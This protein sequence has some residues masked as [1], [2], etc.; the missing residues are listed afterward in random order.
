LTYLQLA[1][2]HL[3]TVLP[4]FVLGTWLLLSSRKGSPGH[5]LIG[6]VYMVLML[7]TAG[8]TLFMPAAVGPRVLNHFGFIHL[9][10][11][12]T[13]NAIPR[14]YLAARQH[15][16]AA[17][18]RHMIALYVGALLIAGAFAFAPG[19]LLHHWLFG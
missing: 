14:A 6:K 1:Y 7:I 2:L 4:A 18:R 13:F 16:L 9:F 11:L 12:L 15:D 5:R 10:S 17:H 3:A 8:L 19:R